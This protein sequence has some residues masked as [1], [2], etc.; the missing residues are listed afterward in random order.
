LAR[1]ASRASA[2][3]ALRLMSRPGEGA[4]GLGCVAFSGTV[5]DVAI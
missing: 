4:V 5:E 2:E 3:S 1:V